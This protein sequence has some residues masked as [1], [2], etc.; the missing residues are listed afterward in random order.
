MAGHLIAHSGASALRVCGALDAPRC[1][2]RAAH[3]TFHRVVVLPVRAARDRDVAAALRKVIGRALHRDAG[4]S[5]PTERS[6]HVTVR[7]TWIDT[8]SVAAVLGVAFCAS[9]S[10]RNH[11]D[12]SQCTHV[13]DLASPCA[14]R[15]RFLVQRQSACADDGCVLCRILL[16]PEADE[17]ASGRRRLPQRT[18]PQLTEVS[19]AW[20]STRDFFPVTSKCFGSEME[21]RICS[22]TFLGTI[23]ANTRS[24]MSFISASD[25]A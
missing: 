1:G 22:R 20:I 12:P 23:S 4:A 7:F 25:G 21:S 14:G 15:A 9:C 16:R 19:V 24:K 10:R 6:V 3:R 8:R 13:H 18:T 11:Q 2:W 5:G 17:R